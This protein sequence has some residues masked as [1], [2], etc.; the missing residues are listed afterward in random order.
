MHSYPH[1]QHAYDF[2][3]M[4]APADFAAHL[5]QMPH[6]P[7]PLETPLPPSS[8][9][10]TAHGAFHLPQSHH[11][12]QGHPLFEGVVAMHQMLGHDL[13]LGWQDMVSCGQSSTMAYQQSNTSAYPCEPMLQWPSPTASILDS[14]PSPLEESLPH[15]PEQLAELVAETAA[16]EDS[17]P[18]AS[19]PLPQHAGYNRF[20]VVVTG[21]SAHE[22][23]VAFQ[24]DRQNSEKA[25][26]KLDPHA[27]DF[28]REKLGEQ[29]WSI[30]SSRLAERRA[31]AQKPKPK[32]DNSQSPSGSSQGAF[33]SDKAGGATVIDFLVKVEVVKGV[34]RTFVPHPYNPLKTLSHS[35]TSAPSGQVTLSRSTVLAL[36]GWSNTQ[37]SYWAR[38]S[39]AISVL[40][41]H[42]D[43]LQ[44]AATALERRLRKHGLQTSMSSSS[45]VSDFLHSAASSSSSRDSAGDSN[46]DP[47][48]WIRLYVTGKGLDVI[49]DEVKKRS[50][51]SPFLRGKHSS[52]DPFGTAS[53]DADAQA[54]GNRA[55][56]YMPTF[57][58]E[59]YVHEVPREI[60][61]STLASTIEDHNVVA[62]RTL[63][64]RKEMSP[65]LG[66]ESGE[67]SSPWPE[68]WMGENT[69]SFTDPPD[70]RTSSSPP[71]GKLLLDSPDSHV[72]V[73]T[74]T[75]LRTSA[76]DSQTHQPPYD[77]LD[78]HRAV[79]MSASSSSSSNLSATGRP[80]KRRLAPAPP[81]NSSLNFAL[82][83]QD[84]N[85]DALRMYNH[86]HSRIHS[87]FS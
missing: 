44:T 2:R 23:T 1:M 69:T 81:A 72:T 14:T 63:G 34:L 43:R 11:G 64:K 21:A 33:P 50:G 51:V 68:G 60:D 38:R 26:A 83:P 7:L 52:L 46:M 12:P 4:Q 79:P 56:V 80:K 29:R 19:Q 82:H 70:S 20:P 76:S 84:Y 85:A 54:A 22:H 78:F 13:N 31:T 75:G 73:V 55:A 40:A 71:H 58:A 45:D 39:E 28:I 17:P 24:H 53:L 66:S 36:S 57:Q 8:Y 37:F 3:A 77:Y 27:A 18:T 42:D 47:E 25:S 41:M 15:T 16:P 32:A 9:D 35:Y 67:S 61:P 59:K 65:A 10:F 6:M 49:I 87:G 30:F 62:M 48:E 74:A 86:G 5:Q